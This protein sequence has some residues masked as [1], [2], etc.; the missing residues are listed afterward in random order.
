M[1]GIVSFL[2]L[3][4]IPHVRHSPMACSHSVPASHVLGR[5]WSGAMLQYVKWYAKWLPAPCWQS[6]LVRHGL[7]PCPRFEFMPM[8]HATHTQICTTTSTTEPTNEPSFS[9]SELSGCW[10]QK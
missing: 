6:P 2:Q 8:M 5:F 4:L 7:S 10:R 1:G 9:A 3:S